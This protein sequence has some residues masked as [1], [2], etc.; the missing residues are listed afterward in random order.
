[1]HNKSRKDKIEKIKEFP[2]YSR[3]ENRMC[4]LTDDDIS[5][6]REMRQS[7]MTYKQIAKEFNVSAQAIFY[8]CLSDEKR[9]QKIKDRI[10]RLREQGELH[11]SW[12]PEEYR[13]YR[14]RKKKLHP[15]LIKYERQWKGDLRKKRPNYKETLK[16]SYLHEKEIGYGKIRNDR[17]IKKW[18][19]DVWAAYHRYRRKGIYKSFEDIR[20]ELL[21]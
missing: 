17:F 8:W 1:M 11:S 19:K 6:V 13:E 21:K 4:K 2:K 16:K 20:K 12:T 9:K 7:G 18:G 5:V 10:E 15:E 3:E 14:E